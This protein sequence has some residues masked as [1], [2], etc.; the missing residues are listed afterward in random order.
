MVHV[1][2]A[3]DGDVVLVGGVD[4]QLVPMSRR[5]PTASAHMLS[6]REELQR[7]DFRGTDVA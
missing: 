4:E 6:A 1:A 3:G 2:G 7:W 5:T